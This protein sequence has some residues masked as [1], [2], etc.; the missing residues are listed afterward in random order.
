M[1][2]CDT[3]FTCWDFSCLAVGTERGYKIYNCDPYGKCY[4]KGLSS[5]L[6]ACVGSYFYAREWRDEHSVHAFLYQS[7]SSCW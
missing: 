7:C 3:H 5:F 4:E 6:S 1:A 2:V